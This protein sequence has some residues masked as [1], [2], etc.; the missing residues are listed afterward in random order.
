MGDLV[1]PAVLPDAANP[2]RVTVAL[3]GCLQE[4][5]VWSQTACIQALPLPSTSIT[6]SSALKP[7]LWFSAQADRVPFPRESIAV[8]VFAVRLAHIS[9]TAGHLK[10]HGA[11]ASG[12]PLAWTFRLS[13]LCPASAVRRS[14]FSDI[15]GRA[16]HPVP[17]RIGAQP[18]RC[19]QPGSVSHGD[20]L[21]RC[22]QPTA[23][24]CSREAVQACEM[25][26]FEN[27]LMCFPSC[28]PLHASSPVLPEA[29]VCLRSTRVFRTGMQK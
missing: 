16:G 14:Q 19:R 8:T 15:L 6:G 3:P 23:H 18:P 21:Q 2:V 5:G 10:C 20:T 26:F 17:F 25:G 28:I 9:A 11:S 13:M 7:E 29:S 12:A 24:Q 27:L 1:P 22:R 4:H